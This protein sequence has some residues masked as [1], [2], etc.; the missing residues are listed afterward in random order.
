MLMETRLL[1]IEDTVK[2]NELLASGEW[3]QP[4]WSEKR[5]A[6]MMVKRKQA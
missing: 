3:C 6:W 5:E 1:E 4:K 2:A